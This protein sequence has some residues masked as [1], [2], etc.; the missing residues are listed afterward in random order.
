MPGADMGGVSASH[1]PSFTDRLALPG[2]WPVAVIVCNPGRM[3]VPAATCPRCGVGYELPH[4]QQ[5]GWDPGGVARSHVGAG[6]AVSIRVNEVVVHQC[7]QG[8]DPATGERAWRPART[9]GADHP[10]V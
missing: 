2:P 1:R 4:R 3:G 10:A 6:G 9:V 5:L 7:E 8:V